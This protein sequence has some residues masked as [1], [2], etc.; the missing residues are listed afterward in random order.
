MTTKV[1][2]IDERNGIQRV[3]PVSGAERGEEKF[4]DGRAEG[5]PGDVIEVPEFWIEDSDSESA[6]TYY[7]AAFLP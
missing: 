4:I 3:T 6:K 7:P 5:Q 1:K 2:L